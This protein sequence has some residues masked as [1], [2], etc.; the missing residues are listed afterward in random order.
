[1]APRIVIIRKEGFQS[2]AQGRFVYDDD[3]IETFA[4]DRADQAFDIRSLPGTSGS[5]E[6][7]GDVQIVDL[8]VEGVAISAVTVTEEVAWSGVPRERLGE[9]GWRPLGSRMLG[10]VEMNDAPALMG[11]NQ[12]DKQE[13]EADGRHDEEVH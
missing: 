5:S 1:M 10:N 7:F 2:A 13:L 6:D 3:V 11:E 12:E 8:S 9:L 4:A